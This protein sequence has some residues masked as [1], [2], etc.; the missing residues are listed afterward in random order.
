MGWQERIPSGFIPEIKKIIKVSLRI[1]N[2]PIPRYAMDGWGDL[3]NNLRLICFV[4]AGQSGQVSRMFLQSICSGEDGKDRSTYL[5]GKHRL[6]QE[7]VAGSVP[8]AELS[9][10]LLGARAVDAVLKL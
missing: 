7:E 1:K 2:H 6:N 8:R 3:S 5:A 10:L 4:D 9:A